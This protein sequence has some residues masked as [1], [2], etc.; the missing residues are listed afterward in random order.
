MATAVTFARSR[1]RAEL[2]LGLLVVA[3]TVGGYILV[4]LA[5]G[6]KLP[7]NVAILLAWV[8]G[9]Y[10]VAHI[11]VRKLAPAADGTLLPL[12]AM[13][14]G[15]GFVM[16]ARLAGGGRDYA[17]QARVQS[18]WVTIAIGVFIATLF[19]V[20]DVRIFARYRYLALLLG[21][22]FMLLPLAPHIGQSR[23]GARLWVGLGPLSFEPNEIA[24]VLL[25]AFFAAYL[26]DKREVLSEGRVRVGR[27]FLP[28]LRDLGPLLL[29][30]G[31]A[32]L[33]LAYEQDIGTSLLF[34]GVFAAMLY[35]TTRRSAYLVLTIVLLVVGALLAY[36]LFGRVRVRVENWTNPWPNA[37]AAGRQPVQGWYALGS[38]GIAG[39]GLGL[40]QPWQVPLAS[41]D[42]MFTSIAEEL[43][44]VGSIGI[45][46]AFMLFVGGAF[47]IAVDA[48]RPFT[49]LFAAG[50]ATIVGLQSFLIIGG[51]TRVIPLTGISLPF[52][53]YGGSSL[54]ANFALLAIL[55]RISDDGVRTKAPP[56]ARVT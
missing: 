34:F 25:V 38:G 5:N 27:W 18:M 14:N 49:K 16:I 6:P 43:G 19:I 7:P 46:A 41:T 40:G 9:L 12:A 29:A 35:M 1:R 50:L 11:A 37:N 22:L 21:I 8:F 51:A 36:K 31:M 45:I 23:N 10:L 30:W 17:Q 56:G 4:A 20:R 32:L 33:V 26:A 53:S 13:L 48:V 2:S 24:K 44:L 15:L 28:S 47:R 3:V 52:V 55:L 39:T 54:V 42:Y